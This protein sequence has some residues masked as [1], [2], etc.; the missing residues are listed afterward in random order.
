LFEDIANISI[1]EALLVTVFS[2]AIVFATLLI[3]DII[4]KGFKAFFYNSDKKS[5][6][7]KTSKKVETNVKST[8]PS[9]DNGNNTDS[10]ED[11]EELVAVITAALAASLARPASE[12]K[13][14]KIRRVS[15]NTSS[16]S[17]AGRLEQMN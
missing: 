5:N 9:I 2:M 7:N 6:A 14:R 15:Q 10:G 12:I 11:E 3:I 17:K 1:S 8:K 16:W 4:L 13:I